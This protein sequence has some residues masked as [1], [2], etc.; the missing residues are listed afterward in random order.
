MHTIVCMGTSVCV[1]GYGSVC[2]CKGVYVCG[3][4]VE[5]LCVC[6]SVTYYNINGQWI[7]SFSPGYKYMKERSLFGEDA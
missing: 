6:Q 5:C 2:V 1:C 7:S 3:R 4:G